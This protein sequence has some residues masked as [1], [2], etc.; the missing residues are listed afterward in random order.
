MMPPTH[1]LNLANAL[2][3]EVGKALRRGEYS[4]VKELLQTVRQDL[5]E[6]E[7]A[8]DA[9]WTADRGPCM[10]VRIEDIRSKG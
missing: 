9:C 4:R 10:V 2:L 7:K 6:F 8:S 1:Y 5:D 3:V